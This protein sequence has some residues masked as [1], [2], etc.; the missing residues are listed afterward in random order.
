MKLVSY[1]SIN[2]TNFS[3]NDTILS[4]KRAVAALKLKWT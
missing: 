2:D 1:F 3:I 4:A